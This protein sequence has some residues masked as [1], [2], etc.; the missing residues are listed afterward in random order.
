LADIRAYC[1]EQVDTL[2]GEVLRFE[3]PQKY[4]VDLSQKLWDLRYQMLVD[5][6]G[7]ASGQAESEQA[8]SGQAAAAE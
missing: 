1:M 7:A 3:N 4:F 5:L 6:S 8:A 2:W